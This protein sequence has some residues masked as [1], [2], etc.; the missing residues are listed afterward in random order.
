M[1]RS[2][3]AVQADTYAQLAAAA[4]TTAER[5]VL[6]SMEKSWRHFAESDR[7]IN[8]VRTRNK[9]VFTRKPDPRLM[10]AAE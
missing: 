6:L 8:E 3:Y 4:K 5:D 10:I 1:Y 7:R 9:A 2:R